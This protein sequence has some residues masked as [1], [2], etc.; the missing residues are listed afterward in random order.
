MSNLKIVN[1]SNLVVMRESTIDSN[2]NAFAILGAYR[3]NGRFQGISNDVLKTVVDSAMT[4][5]YEHLKLVLKAN[6]NLV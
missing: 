1:D 3:S 2:D 6:C 5:D 4:G